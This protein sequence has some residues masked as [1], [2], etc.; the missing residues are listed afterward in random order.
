ML[1]PA[2]DH[3]PR[4][5][6]LGH[7]KHPGHCFLSCCGIQ[8]FWGFAAS[9]GLLQAQVV[10]PMAE[11]VRPVALRGPGPGAYCTWPTVV[12]SSLGCARRA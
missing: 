10:V 12:V 9:P 8:G 1:R 11:A 2:Q 7:E 3:L 6:H 4:L 5:Q